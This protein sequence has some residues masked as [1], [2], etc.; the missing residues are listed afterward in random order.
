MQHKAC[1]YGFSA[2]YV[3]GFALYLRYFRNRHKQQTSGTSVG[4]VNNKEAAEHLED[5]LKILPRNLAKVYPLDS[6][7]DEEKCN[8][9]TVHFVRH[10][11]GHH[12]KAAYTSGYGCQCNTPNSGLQCPY[13]DKKLLDPHLTA[14]GHQQA[15]A[16]QPIT[17]SL[18]VQLVVV[19]P[20]AR[21]VQTALGAF[22]TVPGVP[23]IANENCREQSGQHVCDKRQTRE[24]AS[25]MFPTIDFS[26][27]LDNEDTMW[28]K[29]RETRV[30]VADR[31]DALIRF[32]ADRPE[33]NIAVVAHSSW[34]LT[35][36]NCSLDCS[37]APEMAE[38]FKTGELR[39]MKLVF[40]T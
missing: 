10:G 33:K 24:A 14:L 30:S 21:A 29:E 16:N 18:G 9:K 34:L 15:K 22:Q 26:L 11:E 2:L 27:L 35:L 40:S 1:V 13:T 7:L 19:S 23:Y 3:G 17:P 8:V 6:V 31:G 25:K 20:L 28:T 37:T 36:F 38:W 12:N 39:S 4:S 5:I 32:L